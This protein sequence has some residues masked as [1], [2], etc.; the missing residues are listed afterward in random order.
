MYVCMYPGPGNTIEEHKGNRAARVRPGQ[1]AEACKGVGTDAGRDTSRAYSEQR[2][3]DKGKG[4]ER[5]VAVAYFDCM[6]N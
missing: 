4:S 1:A 3:A 2:G 5:G 6:S